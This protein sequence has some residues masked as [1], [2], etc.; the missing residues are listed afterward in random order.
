MNDQLSD[1]LLEDDD[2]GQA[3]SE[4]SLSKGSSVS[5]SENS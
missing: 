1:Q 2:G 5:I 3:K 4:G